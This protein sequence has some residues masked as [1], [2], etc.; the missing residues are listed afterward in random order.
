MLLGF[1]ISNAVVPA[2]ASRWQEPTETSHSA[3]HQW[4]AVCRL[5]TGW[6]QSHVDSFLCERSELTDEH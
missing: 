4:C 6:D 5:D 2:S 1:S 3:L